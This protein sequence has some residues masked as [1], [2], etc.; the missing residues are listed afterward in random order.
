MDYKQ[1]G[2]DIEEG[3]RAVAQYR[4]LA[5]ATASSAVL[6]SIGSFA[7]MFSLK[8]FLRAG[9]GME[10]P[11]LVSGT[12][13]VGTK[14]DI[15]FKM[16]KYDTVGIDCVA[17]CVNDVLCHGA[18]PLFFLDYLACGKLD[19]DIAADMVK[20]VA[21][22]CRET[23]S[24]LL[25][26]ETAEMPGFYDEGKYDIAGFAVGIA[27]RKKIIDGKKINENDVLLGLASSGPH[28]NGF[29]LIRKAVP[30]LNEDFGGMPIGLALLEPTRLYV[31]PILALMNEVEIRGMANITGGGF[32]ENVPRMFPQAP[33]GGFAFDAVIR[34]PLAPSYRGGWKVPPI[35]ARIAAGAAGRK[36]IGASA[37]KAGEDLLRNDAAIKKL[38]FN[39]YNMG[40]GFVIAL[41]PEQVS[42]AASFLESKGFPCWEIG[43]AAVGKGEVRF[44]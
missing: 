19:A 22:G 28:S 9:E 11:V 1:A 32:Y 30:D 4:E 21:T 12:D 26:G 16:K 36:E 40:I 15:A 7:G 20:G 31:K 43:K 10:D 33:S 6:N 23:G 44:E 35:F 24:V 14:L 27:D 17:M 5:A 37:Q 42:K 8:E 39:T 38:M 25:G 18:K 29:S 2:V 41:A 34:D 13:G 3:Y